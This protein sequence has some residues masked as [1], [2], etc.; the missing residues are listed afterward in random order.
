MIS[1]IF[2]FKKE[3]I[4]QSSDVISQKT[5]GQVMKG[6]DGAVIASVHSTH[7]KLPTTV[8]RPTPGGT[9]PPTGTQERQI[10]HHYG[11]ICDGCDQ[12]IVGVRYKCG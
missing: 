9:A 5:V 2:Q 3:I 7:G 11:I 10:Y 4:D 8:Q 1:I 6:L 12:E